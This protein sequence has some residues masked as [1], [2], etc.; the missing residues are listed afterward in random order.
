MNFVKFLRA[1]F[2]IEHL[3]W[4]LL[5]TKAIQTNLGTFSHKLTCPGI[6]QAY[7]EPCVILSYLKLWYMQNPDI[8]RTPSYSHPCYIQNSA[9]FRTLAYSKSE[10]YTEPCHTSTMK[11][12]NFN[13][14]RKAC[15]VEINILR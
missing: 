9:I 12:T 3:Q 14:F 7:L 8:F 10:A 15:L 5:E 2:S 1:P 11:L 6:I 13:Y 4:L